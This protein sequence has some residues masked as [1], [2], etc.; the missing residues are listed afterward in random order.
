MNDFYEI[1][2]KRDNLLKELSIRDE[3]TGRRTKQGVVYT[4]DYIC[5]YICENS[6]IPYLSIDGKANSV[7]ELIKEHT[8]NNSIDMLKVKVKDIKVLDPA[9]GVGYFLLAAVDVLFDIYK[10]L[11]SDDMSD[12][13]M[14]KYI[15]VNNIYG[16]DIDEL[17]CEITKLNLELKVLEAE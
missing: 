8:T 5:E 10:R 4:P 15:V 17:S 16:V 13:D 6:I 7:D 9:C 3:E 11:F 1:K 2:K 14:M 12:S